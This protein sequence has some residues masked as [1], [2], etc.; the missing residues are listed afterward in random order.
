M[1]R[2]L[3]CTLC[4]LG[5]SSGYAGDTPP[6]GQPNECVTGVE[7]V[8]VELFTNPDPVGDPECRHRH[9]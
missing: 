6:V 8:G 7:G 5:S 1:I 4:L 3:V 2:S 9:A